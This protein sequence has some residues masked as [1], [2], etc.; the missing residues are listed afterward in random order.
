MLDASVRTEKLGMG[1]RG[2]A[3]AC[4]SRCLSG[5]SCL[6]VFAYY[7]APFSPVS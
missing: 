5:V 2:C 4:V 3:H 7:R 1:G 6:S